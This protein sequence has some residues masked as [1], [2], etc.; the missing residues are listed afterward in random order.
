LRIQNLN[1]TCFEDLKTTVKKNSDEVVLHIEG[2]QVD[3]KIKG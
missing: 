1:R 3:S 2:I